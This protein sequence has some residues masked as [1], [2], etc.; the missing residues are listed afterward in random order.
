MSNRP[1]NGDPPSGPYSIRIDDR[2]LEEA[3]AAVEAYDRGAEEAEVAQPPITKPPAPPREA[4]S[5]R[6]P[7]S[8]PPRRSRP[9]EP[10]ESPSLDFSALISVEPFAPQERPVARPTPLPAPPPR[11]SKPPPEEDFSTEPGLDL[12]TMAEEWGRLVAELERTRTERDQARNRAEQEARERL[13]LVARLKRLMES[14]ERDRRLSEEAEGARR[15]Q[16][17]QLAAALDAARQ[18][19]DALNRFRERS[20]RTEEE[21][22]RHGHAPILMEMIPILENLERATIAGDVRPE[23]MLEGLK[24]VIDQFHAALGRQG[25]SRIEASSGTPFEPSIHE[26]VAHVMV[27]EVPPGTVVAELQRGYMLNGRLLRAARVSVAA[28][29]Y[30]PAPAPDEPEEERATARSSLSEGDALALPEEDFQDE[31]ESAIKSD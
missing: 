2:L 24:I 11:S 6:P 7:A 9:P 22:R 21:L 29:S 19:Q 23:R 16:A 10:E 17:S 4:P 15:H 25:I 28:P 31:E 5:P 3:L 30:Q 12:A 1:R 8:E 13:R 20:R 27:E 18:S 26:A 14:T